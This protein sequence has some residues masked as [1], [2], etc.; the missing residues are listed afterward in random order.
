MSRL[1]SNPQSAIR[2]P[3]TCFL[4]DLRWRGLVHQTTD[5]AGLAALAR[6]EAAHRLRRLRSDG[7]QPARRQPVAAADAAAVSAGRAQADR[8]RRRRDG[9]DRRPQRQE[10]GAQSALAE[11][12]RRATSP[13]CAS[14]CGGSSISTPARNAAH[15]GQQLRLDRAVQLSRI[16]ARRRQELS[17]Q[18]DAGQGLGQEP[19]RARRRGH[20]LHRVQ[21]HAAAGVRLRVPV[22][23][24]RLRAASRRQ[25]PVG[26]HHGRHRPGAAD[27]GRAALRP[28]V[29]A[30]HEVR[31]H[32][33]G[34]D[35][36]RARS[37][38]RPS[39]PAR[40]SSINTGSTSTTP[41]SAS[42]CGCSPTL[43]REEIEAL[44]AAR[45]ARRGRARQPDAGWPKS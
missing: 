17:R 9:H 34:Q 36:D 38:S 16:P 43:P 37:G 7:R 27:A 44:D 19:A 3:I 41:T 15:A 40:T 8:R 20:E 35:R 1:P 30:A 10:P 22:R 39:A 4:D 11:T 13:A 26:Q 6:G 18:R 21:L 5:D 28:H 23:Q 31:R 14:R 45:A 33:D 42:A 2:N 12:T 25:R 32:E 29:P 24:V